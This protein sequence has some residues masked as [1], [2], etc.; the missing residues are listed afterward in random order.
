MAQ[1][2]RFFGLALIAL[3]II[4]YVATGAVSITALIP[5]FFGLLLV[6]LGWLARNE[7]YRK[8]VMHV[9][10]VIGVV[11]FLGTVRALAGLLTLLSGGEVQRPAAVISQAIMALLMA[12]FV[13]LCIRSFVAARRARS[14]A[15]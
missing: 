11:G 8:H 3:G 12:L 9:A 6:L 13:G 14:V 5:A 2:T 10:A 15:R 1:T 7:G 4:G